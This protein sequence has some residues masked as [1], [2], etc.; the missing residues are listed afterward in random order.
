MTI[1]KAFS[2]ICLVLIIT[3]CDSQSPPSTS[4]SV[5]V[6][7]PTPTEMKQETS[8]P[9]TELTIDSSNPEP[10]PTATLVEKE[11]TFEKT[12][13]GSR[14][15]RG[16]N[17]LQTQDGGYAIVGYTSS[18]D[19]EQEDVYLVRTDPLGDVIWSMIYGGEGKD[20]GWDVLEL[21]DGGFL[22]VGFTDSFGAGEMDIYLIRTDDLGNLLWERT[23]GGPR[24]EYGWAMAPTSDGGFV[25][26]GQ[27][28]SYG[29]GAEDGY[30]V[31]VNAQGE[32]IWSQT[33]GGPFEDRLFSVDQSADSGFV[34]TGTTTSFGSGNR[35]AYLVKASETGDLVWTQVFGEEQDDV[36]HSVR[37]T[38]DRG[39]IVTGY[40]KSFDA[41][42]YDTWLIKTDEAGE[43]QWQKFY[44]ESGDDR[45]IYGE[46]TD[47]GGYIMT[48]YTTGYDSV[49]WD[50]F[51]VRA[52]SS[53][54]VIWLR[55]FGGKADDTG[56]TVRQT[57]DGGFIL[58]GE[59]YSSGKGGG[60]M[61][62]IKVNQDGDIIEP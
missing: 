46:Q 51:L 53:G 61:Y 42:N 34:L 32:E 60:D 28:T 21:E 16:I 23:F 15:D 27:S 8:A 6:I 35:D 45:T 11:I 38:S 47:D 31:K 62:V 37:Q 10:S 25:L 59:T 26:A 24:S 58:T 3:A 20:N 50:V 9:T 39:F 49:G 22:I 2:C 57:S 13:G 48:G 5:D 41:N 33:F 12:V 7:S 4:E 56:Y 36:G 30:L 29:D 40:T 43:L 55:T 52:D 19:A 18:M 44:G 1:L 17:L 54:A 14:R